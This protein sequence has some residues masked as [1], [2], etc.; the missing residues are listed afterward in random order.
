MDQRERDE[1]QTEAAA[2]L[3]TPWGKQSMSETD[4]MGRRLRHSSQ[5]RREAVPAEPSGTDASAIYS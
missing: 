2:S 4:R 5:R 1:R 3:W